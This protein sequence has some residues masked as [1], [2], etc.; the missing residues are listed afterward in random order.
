MAAADVRFR[1][2]QR[3]DRVFR[4]LPGW[5]GELSAGCGAWGGITPIQLRLT[6]AFAGASL[7]ILP[8]SRGQKR[9][10]LPSVFGRGRRDGEC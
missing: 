2:V 3:Q 1:N 9:A 6:P 10:V 8:P 5:G 7:R 4:T